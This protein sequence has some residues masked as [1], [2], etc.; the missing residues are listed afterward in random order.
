[1]IKLFSKPNCQ[2]CDVVKNYIKENSIQGVEYDESANVGEVRK[3][4]GMQFPMLLVEDQ[5][6]FG[7]ESIIAVLE[8]LK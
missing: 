1:M 4:G 8:Q 2:Y 3:H 6:V 5:G 7:S